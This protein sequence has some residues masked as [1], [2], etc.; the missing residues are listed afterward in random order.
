M[1][2]KHINNDNE[3]AKEV[4]VAG[5][6][7]L[8]VCDFSANWCGPCRYI[9]PI[10]EQIS[11]KYPSALFLK[12]DVDQCRG[13]SQLYSIEAMPTFV[14]LRNN[15]E[16][17]RIRGANPALLEDLVQ[18]N[19]SISNKLLATPQER[20]W[21]HK[22][23]AMSESMKKYEDEV[24]QTLAI[25]LIPVDELKQRSL[26]DAKLDQYMLARNLLDWFHNFF[27]WVKVKCLKCGM[28]GAFVGYGVCT[29][30][31]IEGQA[32]R[33]EL[34]KCSTCQTEI[35]F[36]RYNDPAKLLLTRSG[37]CGEYANAFALCCR[38]VGLRTRWVNDNL[39]HVWVEVWSDS[40][41][42]WLHCDPCENVIDTPLIYD[43]GWGKKHAYVFAFSIDH[44]QDVTWRYSYNQS[45]ALKRRNRCREPIL[46]NFINKL[47]DRLSKSLS[48]EQLEKLKIMMMKELV[49]FL[50]PGNQLRNGSE[51]ESQGRKSGD[52]VWRSD[53][54]ELGSDQMAKND[55]IVLEP[56][57][58][59]ISKGCLI[60]NYNC[61][62]DE[63][64]RTNHESDLKIPAWHSLTY[65]SENIFRKVEQDWKK[66]YLCRKD[67]SKNGRI[68]WRVD[69]NQ[70]SYRIKKI[71]IR[72]GKIELF[73][74]GKATATI[75]CGDLCANIPLETGCVTLDE[76][77]DSRY[78]E[79]SVEL[80][81][82]KGD[83][84]WQH[85]QLFRTDNAQP[86]NNFELRIYFC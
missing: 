22:F 83:L 29:A 39:D 64:A 71:E 52:E 76:V 86:L 79:I 69:H 26:V 68:L 40:L 43:K 8:L 27:E 37:R 60:L 4:S 45:A 20:E 49:E 3:F 24:N 42:R 38:A 66:T 62:A 59:E 65:K 15:Q 18:K 19:L 33:V 55:S 6:E 48:N 63:Y 51:A 41:S 73:N 84:A 1:V 70:Q 74:E 2:V 21:L 32:D 56:S 46:L 28:D 57:A 11:D 80:F 82:G 14:L 35:R 16:L 85:A 9:E 44:I 34:Y 5:S 30:E 58:G 67:G 75:C 12:I 36:P 81:G 53:R 25:S 78:T 17:D 77:S 23:V 50:W 61:V 54:G 10:F 72:L 7:R 31:E 13:T 47:N